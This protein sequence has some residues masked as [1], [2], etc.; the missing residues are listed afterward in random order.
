MSRALAAHDAASRAAV[1][2]NHGIVVKMTGD[3]M[4]AAF[5]DPMDALNATA[6]LQ[7]TLEKLATATIPLRCAPGCIWVWSSDGTTIFSA[8]RLTGRRGS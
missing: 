3:G 8:A 1:E 2:G 5:S 7:Q 4:Y 6:V